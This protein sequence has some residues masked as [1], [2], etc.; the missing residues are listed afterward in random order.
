MDQSQKVK[1][2]YD[3]VIVGAGVAGLYLSKL[4]EKKGINYITF[5]KNKQ[6]GKYGNRIIS[7]T[8][9]KKLKVSK[10]VIIK[11]IKEINFMSPSGIKI[12][13]KDK[14]PRGY[15]TNLGFLEKEIFLSLKD[16]SK[17]IFNHSVENID[18]KKGFLKVK[19]YEI[20]SK[21]IIFASGILQ[22]CLSNKIRVEK[23]RIVFCYTNE[24]EGKDKITTILDNEK[25]HGF[26]AWVMPIKNGLI[27]VG[28]GTDRLDEIKGK[29][30]N[31]LLF[32]I[33]Y[34]NKYK[35]NRKLRQSGGLIPTSL[36]R[37]RCGKNW[38]LIGDA[39]G[40]EALMG[41][42]IHKA[43]DEASLASE[44]IE[45]FINNK[46]SNLNEYNKL[47]EKS[48]GK[49]FYK[50]EKIRNILDNSSNKELDEVFRIVKKETIKGR[51]LI[52]DLFKNIIVNLNKLKR[53]K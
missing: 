36:V 18:L 37:K 28:F 51:G 30:L 50:Q 27:E 16:K 23:P 48:L 11:D 1:K 25:A 17:I 3:V 29:D 41:G 32:S 26:Y 38:I 14:K 22:E 8:A 19:N 12:S 33:Q 44:I 10:K 45:R 47:W 21:I 46:I 40:G 9:F 4:L 49:D 13:K 35:K 2:H 5:E 31:K 6:V 24:I 39:A 42:S 43:V 7:N 53:F 34:I 20:K 52:N 15:V